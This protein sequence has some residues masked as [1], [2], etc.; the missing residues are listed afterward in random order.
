MAIVAAMVAPALAQSSGGSTGTG[1]APTT[2]SG[3]SMPIPPRA[4]STT[5]PGSTMPSPSPSSDATGK[6]MPGG[7]MGQSGTSTPGTGNS[8]PSS[9]AGTAAGT[10][11]SGMDMDHG[12]GSEQVKAVQKALQDKGRNSGPIDG[13][14]GPKTMAASERS[15]RTR[16]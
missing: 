14:M 7:A 5:Q 11:K 6:M 12:P 1:T 15:R 8:M 16:S 13:I 10:P 2:G 3:S 4:P 9:G